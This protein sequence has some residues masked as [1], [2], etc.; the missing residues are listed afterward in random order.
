MFGN[1][2]F[3]S[4]V[5][6]FPSRTISASLFSGSFSIS[7]TRMNRFF[8]ASSIDSVAASCFLNSSKSSPRPFWS[9][10]V[11]SAYASSFAF[12]ISFENAF[13]ALPTRSVDKSPFFANSPSGEAYP[14]IEIDSIA[15]FSFPSAPSI[16]DTRLTISSSFNSLDFTR[17]LPLL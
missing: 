7:K 11:A 6:D 8:S 4:W 13:D 17:D 15:I 12:D 2:S 10:V 9:Y 1:T 14:L 16:H 5:Y 3:S